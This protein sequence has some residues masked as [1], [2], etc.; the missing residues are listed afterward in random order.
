MPVETYQSSGVGTIFGQRGAKRGTPNWWELYRIWTAF[1]KVFAG[2]GPLFC[3]KNKRSLKKGL[4]RLP[5][6]FVW[7]RIQFSGG[8]GASRPGGSCLP[9]SRAYV[10]ESATEY[11]MF[12][13]NSKNMKFND[14]VSLLSTISSDQGLSW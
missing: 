4:C 1:G 2:F 12:L 8:R 14:T 9:T 10:S 7:P 3:P 13:E 5:T 6:A 11:C